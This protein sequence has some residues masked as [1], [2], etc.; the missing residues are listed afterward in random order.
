[1]CT[2]VYDRGWWTWVSKDIVTSWCSAI[3]FSHII[4]DNLTIKN[5]LLKLEVKTTDDQSQT[6]I[7]SLIEIIIDLLKNESKIKHL[8]FF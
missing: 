3:V 4:G 2:I 7:K 1:M 8:S 5:Q 6:N